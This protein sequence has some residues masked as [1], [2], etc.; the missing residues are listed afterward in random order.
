MHSNLLIFTSP[1]CDYIVSHTLLIKE[2]HRKSGFQTLAKNI[3]YST[4]L[5]PFSVPV[6]NNGLT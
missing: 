1:T 2:L 4:N 5:K 6:I 3:P